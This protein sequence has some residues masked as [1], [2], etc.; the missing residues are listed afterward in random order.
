MRRIWILIIFVMIGCKKEIPIPSLDGII[1]TTGSEAV[2][3]Q[4]TH[5]H[6][7]ILFD[8]VIGSTNNLNTDW[9]IFNDS[10]IILNVQFDSIRL[11][12][13]INVSCNKIQ[14]QSIDLP[15]SIFI[16]GR[17]SSNTWNE[18]AR[19]SESQIKALKNTNIRINIE[20]QYFEELSIKIKPKKNKAVAFSEIS[21]N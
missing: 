14:D 7:N 2:M 11:V 18:I 8:Q 21:L 20:G 12:K 5:F 17:A 3:N 15:A 13:S 10:E 4:S 9:I 19:L 6:P 16:E 1:V